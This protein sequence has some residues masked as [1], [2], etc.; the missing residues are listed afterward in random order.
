[1]DEKT[2]L[3]AIIDANPATVKLPEEAAAAVRE[4]YKL[5]DLAPVLE[6][7]LKAGRDFDRGRK[8]F[9]RGEVLR[10]SP[11]R[12][13]GRQ[14][15]PGPDRR[16]RPVQPRDLLESIID[17]SKEI[18]DQYQAVEIRTKDERVVIGRIVNLNATPCRSTPTC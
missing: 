8:L 15:R 18:S 9:A 2:A 3:N 12:Q 13:R 16:R 10:L 5:D 14:Q 7:G 17:P 1:M 11:L 4:G 6:K